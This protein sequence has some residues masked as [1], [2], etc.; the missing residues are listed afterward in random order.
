[1][2]KEKI[3]YHIYPELRARKRVGAG[4]DILIFKLHLPH[5]IPNSMQALHA[6]S[7]LEIT[8]WKGPS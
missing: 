3:D 1:M 8:V 4:R 6:L 5:V 2:R 7:H